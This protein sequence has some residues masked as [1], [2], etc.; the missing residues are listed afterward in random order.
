MGPRSY[1]SAILFLT[2][3]KDA[4]QAVIAGQSSARSCTTGRIETIT[5]AGSHLELTMPTLIFTRPA[6]NTRCHQAIEPD[7][8]ISADA[9]NSPKAITELAKVIT[10]NR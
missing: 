9:I 4:K 8:F 10:E 1:S 3:L 6:G 7:I 2:A 5:L